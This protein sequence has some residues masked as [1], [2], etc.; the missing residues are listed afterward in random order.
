MTVTLEHARKD[1]FTM[2]AIRETW[3]A[4]EPIFDLQIRRCSDLE[5]A[6]AIHFYT[7]VLK[8]H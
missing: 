4:S 2:V 1:I 3:A 8:L 5:I 7:E 6:K